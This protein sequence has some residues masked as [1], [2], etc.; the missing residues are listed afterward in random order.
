[1]PE[2]ILAGAISRT[3]I[4]LVLFITSIILLFLMFLSIRLRTHITQSLGGMTESILKKFTIQNGMSASMSSSNYSSDKVVN[5]ASNTVENGMKNAGS[6]AAGGAIGGKGGSGGQA[7]SEGKSSLIGN[8]ES[9]G[10]YAIGNSLENEHSSIAT[11]S[12][13]EKAQNASVGAGS[14]TA[15]STDKSQNSATAT[16]MNSADATAGDNESSASYTAD[17][18]EAADDR[19]SD[20]TTVGSGSMMSEKMSDADA[21]NEARDLM[22]ADSLA[23]ASSEGGRGGEAESK[24]IRDAANTAL[25]EEKYGEA[26]SASASV[27]ARDG[28]TKDLRAAVDATNSDGALS[29]YTESID[30]ADS[31]RQLAQVSESASN[32]LAQGGDAYS[33]G[34]EAEGKNLQAA[35]VSAD[36][37]VYGQ[38]GAEGAAGLGGYGQAGASGQGANAANGGIA[39][40]SDNANIHGVNGK[41]GVAG[42]GGYG[43]AGTTACHIC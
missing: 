1:M 26:G 41:N 22:F 28:D 36:G 43:Q 38:N 16:N 12:A 10:I 8:A 32:S 3:S 7:T 5:S 25:A 13:D 42:E 11:G 40:A 17:G 33:E 21:R 14:A 19:N 39:V 34:Q 9:G 15:M 6:A 35:V 24:S 4:V 29:P 30:R 27:D 23:E 37:S 20:I 2:Y 18:R 31:D